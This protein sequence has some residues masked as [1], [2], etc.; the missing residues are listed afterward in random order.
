MGALKC[1]EYPR[2]G[3]LLAGSCSYVHQNGLKRPDT[4]SGLEFRF[5]SLG[6]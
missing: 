6:S 5:W 3:S 2:V 4:I 1:E